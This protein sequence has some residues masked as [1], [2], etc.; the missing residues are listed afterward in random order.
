MKKNEIIELANQLTQETLQEAQKEGLVVNNRFRQ[1]Y[2]A[3]IVRGVKYMLDKEK[4]K[5]E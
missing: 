5:K 4:E 3:G 1:G 2:A